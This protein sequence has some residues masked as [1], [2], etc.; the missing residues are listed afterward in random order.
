MQYLILL[1]HGE[2]ADKQ[3]GQTDFERILTQRGIESIR[4]LSS[5]LSNEKIIPDYAIVSPAERTKQTAQILFEAL[6]LKLEP[7]FET[8]IYNGDDLAYKSLL[9]AVH[10]NQ[11]CVLLV[12]HNPSISALVGRLTQ[13]SFSGLHPGQAAILTFEKEIMQAEFVKTLGPFW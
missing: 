1:R 9:E 12:G 5:H 3:H 7:H 6:A 2:S 11:K 4:R 8:D 10:G 13:K